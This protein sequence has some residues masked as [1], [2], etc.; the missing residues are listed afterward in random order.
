MKTLN[1]NNN[2]TIFSFN[3]II[4]QKLYLFLTITVINFVVCFCQNEIPLSI[5]CLLTDTKNKCLIT[6]RAI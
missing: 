4:I 5:M 2:N 6:L 3:S 1:G